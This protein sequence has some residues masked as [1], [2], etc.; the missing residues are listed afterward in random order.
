MLKA[1]KSVERPKIIKKFY[2]TA[3]LRENKDW[4]GM[5]ECLDLFAYPYNSKIKNKQR[6][7]LKYTKY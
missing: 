2:Y 5:T 3:L 1:Q 7:D 6:I 4:Y